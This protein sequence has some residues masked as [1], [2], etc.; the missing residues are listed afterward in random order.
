MFCRSRGFS[1]WEELVIY[2]RRVRRVA[3]GIRARSVGDGHAPEDELRV[4]VCAGTLN[5][6]RLLLFSGTFT[7]SNIFSFCSLFFYPVNGNLP[8]THSAV[9]HSLY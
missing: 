4:C 1:Q 8:F 3:P 9:F 2:E 5:I 6:S 7:P